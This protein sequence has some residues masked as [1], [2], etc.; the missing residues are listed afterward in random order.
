MATNAVDRNTNSSAVF[1]LTFAA[2]AE[3]HGATTPFL[4]SNITG[5]PGANNDTLAQIMSSYWISFAQTYDPNP[6]RIADAPYWPSYVSNGEGSAAIGESVGFDTLAVTYTTIGPA[7]DPDASV[8]CDFF[9]KNQYQVSLVRD[10][11]PSWPYADSQDRY[12]IRSRRRV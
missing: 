4:C 6:A 2:G 11:C 9:A 7:P 1:K 10:G 12:R 8:K 3:T 5:W